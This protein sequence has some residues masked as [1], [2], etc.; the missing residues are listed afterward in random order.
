MLQSVDIHPVRR[1]VRR[2]RDDGIFLRGGGVVEEHIAGYAAVGDAEFGL[3]N[4]ELDDIALVRAGRSTC[5][6]S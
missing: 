5:Q 3:W 1:I 6:H 2:G 4:S